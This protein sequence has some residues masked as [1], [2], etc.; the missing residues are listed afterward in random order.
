ME[1]TCGSGKLFASCHG[2]PEHQE[3]GEPP[4]APGAGAE[5]GDD[6]QTSVKRYY[7]VLSDRTK[8]PYTLKQMRTAVRE[9]RLAES[10]VVRAE[11][12]TVSQ[13][14][15]ALL[16]SSRRATRN[17]D[18]HGP[19]PDQGRRARGRSVQSSPGTPL[20]TQRA[21]FWE[22]S[23]DGVFCKECVA[24][25][26][27]GSPGDTSTTNGSGRMFY[28]DAE[29]CPRCGSSV[30]VLWFVITYIPFIPLATYRYKQVGHTSSGKRFMAHETKRRWRQVLAHWVPLL[31]LVALPLVTWTVSALQA[32][33]RR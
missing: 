5:H 25:C 20:P 18:K 30:R 12:E 1:C 24:E 26:T 27:V 14:L 33:L 13:S 19:R 6:V 17:D 4:D 3:P 21:A 32:L 28:G 11:G 23:L 22:Q 2:A 31:T 7:I 10:S 16:D 29:K 9:G 15:S 8:G